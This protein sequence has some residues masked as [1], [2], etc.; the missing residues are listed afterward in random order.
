MSDI[1]SQ[2]IILHRIIDSLPL[3]LRRQTEGFPHCSLPLTTMRSSYLYQRSE[4]DAVLLNIRDDFAELILLDLTACHYYYDKIRKE[5]CSKT[6]SKMI[7]LEAPL[8]HI[9][10]RVELLKRKGYKEQDHIDLSL[11]GLAAV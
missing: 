8:K 9:K 10:N 2:R 4:K 7:K 11:R 3:S 5:I 6:E 1:A